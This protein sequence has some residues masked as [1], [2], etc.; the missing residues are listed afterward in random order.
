MPFR[1]GWASRLCWTLNRPS[2]WP[3]WSIRWR[4]CCIA[5]WR[6]RVDAGPAYTARFR[7][8]ATAAAEAVHEAAH[9]LQDDLQHH[10]APNPSARTPRACRPPGRR[11]RSTSA[12]WII[13]T[14]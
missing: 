7:R 13:A 4:I 12:S 8:D 11:C 6:T 1:S 3:V 14:E 10:P 2:N 5:I 9:Q